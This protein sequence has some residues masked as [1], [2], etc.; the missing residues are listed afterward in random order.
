MSANDGASPIPETVWAVL[1]LWPDL[2]HKTDL[3]DLRDPTVEPPPPTDGDQIGPDTVC[4][5][6]D[7]L[8]LG[9]RP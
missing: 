2:R 6:L 1:R 9:D 8:H 3:V 7:N 5:E 4:P